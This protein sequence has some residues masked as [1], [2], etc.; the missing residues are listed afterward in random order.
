M[1]YTLGQKSLAQLAT[2]DEKMQRVVKR[3]IEL[4]G[5][6]FT[7]LE[8]VRTKQR[9]YELFA[10]GRSI[11]ELR[12][13]GVPSSVLAQPGEKKVTWTLNSKHFAPVEG[14]PGRAVDLAPFPIDWTSM[15]KFTAIKEAMFKAAAELG[16]RIRWGGDWD[17]DGKTEHGE[18]DFGHFELR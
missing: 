6:D 2:V 12:K 9:Q 10:K 8:G 1:S 18:D 16:V 5:Q 13:A 3:A 15:A 14:Q 4:T 11:A 17:G 7:V